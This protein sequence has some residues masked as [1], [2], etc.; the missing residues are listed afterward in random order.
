MVVVVS[1]MGKT[2]DALVALAHTITPA[3]DLREMDTVLATGAQVTIGLLAMALNSM[4]HPA[5]SF[6]GPQVGMVTDGAHT[7][8]QFPMARVPHP[9]AFMIRPI[10]FDP[11]MSG[12]G[13]YG[14]HF[15]PDPR[16]RSGYDDLS[17]H[18]R[19]RLPHNHRAVVSH[20]ARA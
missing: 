3:P 4:G 14:A 17:R 8:A 11:H 18:D 5:C 1:A 20:A 6:T 9:A 19:G 7:R 10:A 2:T 13:R 12:A 16:W 15:A